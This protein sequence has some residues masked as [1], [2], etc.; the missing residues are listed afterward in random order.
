MGSPQPDGA[1][2]VKGGRK[3]AIAEGDPPLRACDPPGPF[4]FVR[5][6]RTN[7]RR[8]NGRRC[9]RKAQNGP[10]SAHPEKAPYREAAIANGLGVACMAT[11]LDAPTKRIKENSHMDTARRRSFYLALIFNS[12]TPYYRPAQFACQ[13]ARP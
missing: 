11:R 1:Q 13:A 3:A 10:V 4:F 2:A 6:E 8:I 7:V 12:E 5:V 9:H